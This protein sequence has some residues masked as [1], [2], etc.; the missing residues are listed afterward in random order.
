MNKVSDGYV[1]IK[2]K[3]EMYWLKQAEYLAYDNLVKKLP[4][5]GYK[6]IPHTL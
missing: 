5:Y 3:K 6:H 4:P 1:Y 2:I